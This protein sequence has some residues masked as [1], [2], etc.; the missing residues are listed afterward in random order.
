MNERARRKDTAVT[1]VVLDKIFDRKLFYCKELLYLYSQILCVYHQMCHRGLV[2][3]SFLRLQFPTKHSHK[4]NS[5]EKTSSL[6]IS[7]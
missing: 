1:D 5:Q 4:E 2:K 3:K 6:L 7:H